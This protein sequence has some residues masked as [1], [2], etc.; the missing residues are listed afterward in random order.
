MKKPYRHIKLKQKSKE[1][2][3]WR[4]ENGIGGSEVAS[5]LATDSKEL[6]ELVYQ[7]PIQ[8]HLLKLGEPVTRFSGN[9][10]SE[11][12]AHQEAAILNRLRYYD[13]ENPDQ[14]LI[15]ENMRSCKKINGIY[16]PGG[17]L[18]NP[19]I[20]HLFYSMDAFMTESLKSRK[21]KA[22]LEAKLTTSMET[23]RYENKVSPM[24]WIQVMTGLMITKLPVGYL[25]SLID[26]K[27]FSVLKIEPDREVFEW[28]ETI[29]ASFWRKVLRAR[30]IKL[31]Y[32]IPAYYNVPVYMF[33]ER[34]REGVAKL[35]ELEPSLI[36]SENEIAFL[37]QMITPRVE[38]VRRLGSQEEFEE[39]V[40][41]LKACQKIAE[42]EAEKNKH[43]GKMISWLNG[44][45]VVDFPDAGYY[46]YKATKKGV[47][48][49][50]VKIKNEQVQYR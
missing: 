42:A 11:E 20:P 35:N 6:S 14:M 31:E 28:I 40:G 24:H 44:Y 15:Y 2:L 27:W 1:W 25:I 19:S 43:Y 8:L 17:T 5:A 34:Q 3:E 12:G 13:L 4:H 26:G 33:D 22:L 9:V 10:A 36:G 41:Y 46:S 50:N 39:A 16:Q 30:I 23:S 37:K 48:T 18:Q 7:T 29:S 21:P 49:L 45:N 38:E 47:N 32:G